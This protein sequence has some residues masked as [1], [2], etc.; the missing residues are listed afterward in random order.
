MS[1]GSDT[2]KRRDE[3]VIRKSEINLDRLRIRKVNKYGFNYLY[4]EMRCK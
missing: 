4:Q 2:T 1:Q 3:E